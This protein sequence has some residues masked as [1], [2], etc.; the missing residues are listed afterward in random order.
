MR[1]HLTIMSNMINELR[2]AGHDMTDK[3]QVQS[4]IPSLPSN[5]EH[6]R[7]NLTHN[8]NIKTFDD[9]ARHVELEEDHLLSEKPAN[10]AFMRES[11]SRGAKGSRRKKIGKVRVSKRAKEEMK[12][13]LV[14]KSA[15]VGNAVA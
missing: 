12:Q 3:Q 13:V 6:M 10:E 1:Q 14:D 2:A 15:S 8:E 11:K 7:V 9:V 5:W 4:V